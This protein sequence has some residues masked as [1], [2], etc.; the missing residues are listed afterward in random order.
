M[1]NIIYFSIRFSLAKWWINEFTHFRP[2]IERRKILMQNMTE[3]KGHIMFSEVK[4]LKVSQ[5][6]ICFY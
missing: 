2:I 5:F 3:I 4:T 1:Y 6:V